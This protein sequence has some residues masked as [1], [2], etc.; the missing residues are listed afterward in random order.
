MK[1]MMKYA[2]V[3]ALALGLAGCQPEA[4]KRNVQSQ[5]AKEAADSISIAENAEIENIKA[6]ITLT[7]QPGLV[8]YVVLF[9]EAGQPVYYTAVKGKITSGAKRLTPPDRSGSW[10]AGQNNVVRQAPSDEGT[11]GS[12]NEYIFFW[13]PEGTY[14]QWAGKYLYSDKPIRLKIEPVVVSVK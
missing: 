13:T 7:S 11:W 2:L 1:T 12:S 4:E 6:R 10:G 5:K 3:A 14:I 8:G 9:N